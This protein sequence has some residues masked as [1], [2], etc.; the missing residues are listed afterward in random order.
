VAQAPTP[1]DAGEVGRDE[2][3]ELRAQEV[4]VGADE[5]DERRG[6][7]RGT[8][9]IAWANARNGTGCECEVIGHGATAFVDRSP[10]VE[11]RFGFRR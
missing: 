8:R 2:R 11:G 4:T 1:G 6:R 5:V 3:L 7:D 10:H 9:R